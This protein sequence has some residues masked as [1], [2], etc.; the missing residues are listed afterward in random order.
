MFKSIGNRAIRIIKHKKEPTIICR[1]TE[2]PKIVG[3]CNCIDKCMGGC[4]N[5]MAM[6]ILEEI[7][8]IFNEKRLVA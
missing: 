6:P 8:V 7:E 3:D 2:K 4:T 1:F 5:M